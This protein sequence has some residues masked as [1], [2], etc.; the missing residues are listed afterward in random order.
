MAAYSPLPLQ[1]LLSRYAHGCTNRD[2]K[3][4]KDK[5]YKMLSNTGENRRE[6]C[7]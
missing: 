1:T 2:T 5:T 7:V 4:S 6:D 3:E